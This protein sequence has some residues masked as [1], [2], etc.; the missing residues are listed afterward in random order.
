MHVSQTGETINAYCDMPPK[1][2]EYQ[3]QKITETSIV[4]Q[5]FNK[6]CSRNNQYAKK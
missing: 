4:S 6:R 3:S 1:K 2:T 5:R